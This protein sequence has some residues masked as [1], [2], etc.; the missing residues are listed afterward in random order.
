MVFDYIDGA[1]GEGYGEALNRQVL[2]SVRLQ[3]AALVNVEQR[4]LNVDVFGNTSSIP[5]GVSPMGMC[6]LSSPGADLMLARAAAKHASPVGVSTVASTSMERMIE[7]A[8]GHAWFQLYFSGDGRTAGSLID[9]AEASGYQTLVITVDVPEIGRRPRELAHGFKMP[10]RIGLRQF[11]DFACH[12]RWSLSTLR[13][14][15]PEM[16]NFGGVNG[17]FDRTETRARADW[18]DLQRI[19]DRWRGKLVVKGVLNVADAKRLQA[20]GVDAI[21]ISSHGGRQLDGSP[22]AITML[23]RIRQALGPDYPLFYDSGIRSGEDM[24]KAYALGANFVFI[25][26][27]ALF[28]MAAQGEE[29]LHTLYNVLCDEA[30]I[31]MAQ[32]GKRTLSEIGD[33]V[34]WESQ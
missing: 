29:G 12:P 23:Q 5:F 31:T 8:Q 27:A 30:S 15:K 20:A 4:D 1:A 3:P 26:R 21:Q 16:A 2:Q 34:L 11:I 32:L 9:R 13:H 6:N 7:V 14:G 25:G 24:V 33:D 22:P 18:T 19:R 10:F 17:E 28:A